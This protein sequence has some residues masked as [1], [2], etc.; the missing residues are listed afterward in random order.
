MDIKKE[1]Y[2]KSS[3]A[4]GGSRITKRAIFAL[5]FSA[6]GYA[7]GRVTLPFGASPFGIGAICAAVGWYALPTAIGALLSVSGSRATAYV[8]ACAA[9]LALRMLVSTL[10]AASDCSDRTSIRR[11]VVKRMFNE[12]LTLRTLTAAAAAFGYS[13]Y[14]VISGGFLFYDV[15][16]AAVSTAGAAVGT[17][18]LGYLFSRSENPLFTLFNKE[19]DSSDSVRADEILS[20]CALIALLV[21][22][23]M[24]VGDAELFG[25]SIAVLLQNQLY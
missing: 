12:P 10:A 9:A 3:G 4:E 24:G 17:L 2:L 18:V 1:L 22:V 6:L 25:I 19:K 21:G 23:V 8:I 13:L 14:F 7:L 5:T 16:S 11:E 20:I 15:F